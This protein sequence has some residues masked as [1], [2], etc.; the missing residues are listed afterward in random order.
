MKKYSLGRTGIKVTELCFGALPIGPLQVNISVEEGARLIRIALEKGINFIDTAEGYKTYPHIKRA[1]EDYSGEVI[2]A[3]KSPATT[4]SEMEKS[5]QDALLSLQRPLIDI[6]HL[7]AARSTASVFEERAGAWQC[8]KDYKAKGV[9]RAIGISTHDVGA[10]KRAIEIEEV[11]VI[12]PII[13]LLGMGITGGNL[14]DMIRLIGEAE[15]AGKGVYAMK[16]LAGGHLIDRLEEALNFVR[17]IRGISSVAV[18]MLNL[19]ELELN[20]AIFNDEKL[21]PGLN[22][23]QLKPKKSLFIA[24]F[25]KGCGTC[26]DAC[27]NHALSLKNGKAV[28][29]HNLCILCGYCNPVCPEF[30]IRLI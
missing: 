10:V 5:I 11:D 29:D 14:Q 26:V 18:G 2:I 25:C 12:F 8:L 22:F 20:I 28:V 6:F 30:A 3:T 17:N 24:G 7:H 15:K 19:Q 13:N 16:A 23:E 21:S 9:I 4:Y 27:P 1:L